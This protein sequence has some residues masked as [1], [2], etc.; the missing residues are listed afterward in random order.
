MRLL[1]ASVEVYFRHNFGRRYLGMLFLA[2]LASLM[3]LNFV[4]RPPMLMPIFVLGQLLLTVYHSGF[5]FIRRYLAKPE[6]HSF[7]TGDSP[8]FWQ[9]LRLGQVTVQRYIEPAVSFLLS[10]PILPI[11]PVLGTWLGSSALALFAKEQITRFQATT[12][13]LDAAD[14]RLSAQTLNS[15]LNQY[16]NRQSQGA[17]KSHRARLANQTR[18]KRP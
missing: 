4:P 6:P 14:A 17:Q 13:V 1:S 18:P 8:D 9:R 12:R 2:L 16:L 3:W 7:F 10:L 11:D 15:S 5:V